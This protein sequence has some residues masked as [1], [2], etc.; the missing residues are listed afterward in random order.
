M[1]ITNDD[2]NAFHHFAQVALATR[3][4]DSLQELVALWELDHPAP[5]M[6][7][8]NLVA[9]RAAI[10]DMENGDKG[11]PARLVVDELRAELAARQTP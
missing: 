8:E 2:L 10:R 3:G 11:R 7:A 5:Q 1:A 6:H 9:V 4:A